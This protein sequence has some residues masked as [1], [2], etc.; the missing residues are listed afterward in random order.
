MIF[1]SIVIITYPTVFIICP[2]VF[3]AAIWY[4][5]KRFYLFIINLYGFILNADVAVA[6]IMN[7]LAYI[8]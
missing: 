2:T 7:L 5:W 4:I 8:E 1:I 3:I 6:L